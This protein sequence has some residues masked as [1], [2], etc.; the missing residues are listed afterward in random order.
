MAGEYQVG[1]SPTNN[2]FTVNANTNSS[3]GITG[4]LGG[5]SGNVWGINNN[6]F[7]AAKATNTASTSDANI[8]NGSTW[9]D[10]GPSPAG[11]GYTKGSAAITL[12]SN[13][14]AVGFFGVST[15]TSPHPFFDAYSGGTYAGMVDL[16]DLTGYYSTYNRGQAMGINDS[17]TIVGWTFAGTKAAT[18]EYAFVSG[19]TAGTIEPLSY[20]LTGGIADF[21]RLSQSLAID[22]AGDIVGT[23]NQRQHASVSDFA[24]G[25]ARAFDAAVG[26]E[27]L[28]WLAGLRLAQAE[29][30]H[31]GD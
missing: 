28:A 13:N 27:R 12:D 8:W 19:T 23:D 30:K 18:S 31:P 21:T 24:G 14:D 2:P 5:G 3:V 9:I 29:V 7:V 15:A 6:G 10:L 20:L 26:G 22:N 1:I 16:G 4:S 25:D 17:G 11:S